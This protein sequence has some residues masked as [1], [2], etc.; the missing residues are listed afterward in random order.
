MYMHTGCN[1]MPYTTVCGVLSNSRSE[2]LQLNIIIKGKVPL[3]L[4][5]TDSHYAYVI[6][7]YIL[8]AVMYVNAYYERCTLR[9]TTSSK[10]T[11]VNPRRAYGTNMVVNGSYIMACTVRARNKN[12]VMLP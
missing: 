12:T 4:N 9:T 2:W 6:V 5:I 3:L 1:N 10:H 11:V 8:W 7:W